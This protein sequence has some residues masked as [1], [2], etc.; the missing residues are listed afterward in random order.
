MFFTE[1]I[2]CQDVISPTGHY[3]CHEPFNESRWDRGVDQI[4]TDGPLYGDG[5]QWLPDSTVEVRGA[6]NGE[7]TRENAVGLFSAY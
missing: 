7:K 4:T 2:C 5:A 1:L 3:L 6:L